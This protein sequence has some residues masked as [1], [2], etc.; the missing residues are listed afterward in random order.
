VFEEFA[1]AKP[2][3]FLDQARSIKLREE[4]RADEIL[5]AGA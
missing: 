4:P 2:G 5:E 1:E 3:K